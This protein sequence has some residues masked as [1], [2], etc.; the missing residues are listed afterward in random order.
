MSAA[1]LF[2]VTVT[3]SSREE[4]VLRLGEDAPEPAGREEHDVLHFGNPQTSELEFFARL[5]GWNGGD[6]EEILRLEMVKMTKRGEKAGPRLG[7]LLER[8]RGIREHAA[9]RHLKKARADD[10]RETGEK[11]ET[12]RKRLRRTLDALV[13]FGY[14]RDPEKKRPIWAAI[15]KAEREATAAR[16]GQENL[17]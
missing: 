8:E 16:V 12:H 9:E 5:I 15:E 17:S 10:E 3:R 2:D 11:A 1:R 7:P 4:H 14:A 6:P 13:L